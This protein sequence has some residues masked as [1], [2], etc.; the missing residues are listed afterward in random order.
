[1]NIIKTLSSVAI[2]AAIG[3]ASASAQTPGGVSGINTMP[4]IVMAG[5]YDVNKLPEAAHKFL[6]RHFGAL[7]VVKCEQYFAKGQVEVE[8]SNG[9]DVDFDMKGNVLEV[10]APDGTYLPDALVRELIH[11][12]AY[13]R[14]MKD[15]YAHRVESI[16]YKNNKAV[17]VSVD[18]P[19]PDT[20]I[21]DLN[22]ILLVMED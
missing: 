22:G 7:K 12:D 21:F 4:G 13:D 19:D 16:E 11:K 10:D 14:L 2:A 5:S 18:R 8:L 15:G 20:Y 9:V 3:L 1:M 17:E 6:T